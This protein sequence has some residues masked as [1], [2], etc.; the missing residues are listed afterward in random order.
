MRVPL[1]ERPATMKK[2]LK[3]NRFPFDTGSMLLFSAL[4]IGGAAT[5]YAQAKSPTFGPGPAQTTTAQ[6]AA[7]SS[8]ASAFERAD[9]NHDGQLSPQ[10]AAQL[11]AIA[12]R[13]K[14]LDTDG[15]GALSRSEFDKGAQQKP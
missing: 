12:G 3:Q 10:E 5:A 7:A 9:I 4:A 1:F 14:Q 6:P 15:N 8:A 11:P 2:T 13:F